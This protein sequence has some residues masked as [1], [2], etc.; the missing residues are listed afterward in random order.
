MALGIVG[1]LIFLAC[2]I[3]LLYSL[4]SRKTKKWWGIGMSLGLILFIVGIA[5]DSGE[6]SQAEL[7]PEDT[8]RSIIASELGT[9]NREGVEKISRIDIVNA[10]YGYNIDIYFAIDDNLTED[11]VK[12]GARLDVL[13]TMGALYTRGYDI[14]W[15]DMY[16]AF[17]MVDSYGNTSETEV[18]HAR[19]GRETAA[20]INWENMTGDGLLDILDFKVIHPA[21]N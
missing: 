12:S 20:K 17:S 2:L 3:L 8:I 4:V 10:G 18:I 11:F 1:A 15:I 16:G 9:C 13:D 19:L 5:T 7:T 14:Q 21:F 6:S